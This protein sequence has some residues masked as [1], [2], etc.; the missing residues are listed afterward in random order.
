[1]RE[2]FYLVFIKSVVLI[3]GAIALPNI[4]NGASG[5]TV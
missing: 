3:F 1:M 4:S 5:A 2:I